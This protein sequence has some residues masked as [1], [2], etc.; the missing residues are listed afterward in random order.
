MAKKKKSVKMNDAMAERVATLESNPVFHEMPRK[1]KKVTL[2]PRFNK[3]FKD[4]K[5]AS[6]SAKID[7]RGR[8]VG[9][10]EQEELKAVYDIESDLE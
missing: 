2:D 8:P 5:F 1:D 4:A 9:K 7:R 3:M 6:T 10:T